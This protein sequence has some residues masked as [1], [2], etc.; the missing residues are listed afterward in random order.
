MVPPRATKKEENISA[1]TGS[2]MFHGLLGEVIDT[3]ARP[4]K[5]TRLRCWFCRRS[6]GSMAGYRM[7]PRLIRVDLNELDGLLIPT[8]GNGTSAA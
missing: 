1:A 6:D 7:G 4:P 2:A 3:L 8:A 5:P